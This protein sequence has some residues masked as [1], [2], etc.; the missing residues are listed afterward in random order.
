MAPDGC[1]SKIYSEKKE[2]DEKLTQPDLFKELTNSPDFFI[3]YELEKEKIQKKEQDWESLV[4]ELSKLK[5]G[6]EK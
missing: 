2:L 4:L 6:D 3:N 1:I 5:K